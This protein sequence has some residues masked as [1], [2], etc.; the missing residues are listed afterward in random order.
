MHKVSLIMLP[1]LDG[2]G[3]LFKR[4]IGHLPPSIEPVVLSYPPDKKLGYTELVPIVQTS[5]QAELPTGQP[6]VLLGESFGGPLS[7]LV[8]DQQPEGLLGII[9]CAS[10]LSCP[11]PLVPLW[12]GTLLPSTPFRLT[13][14][15]SKIKGLKE[16]Y[17]SEESHKAIASVRP[18]VWA[19]R[20]REVIGI[21]VSC[22]LSRTT[23]P[24]LYI[25]GKKDIVV[26]GV[27]FRKV[28]AI[29]N[30]TQR[31]Q[32]DTTHMVLQTRPQQSAAAIGSFI[33][34]LAD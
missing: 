6:F 32:I 20:L 15:I 8:A 4:T 12:A 31:V 33:E 25:Q 11:H 1:G 30:D 27:N 23:L 2:T 29:R 13:A 19:H 18:E 21:D 7:L 17:W 3:K 10:F 14:A 9:L 16:G 34:Q 24:L 26:P 28:R 5:I 22:E